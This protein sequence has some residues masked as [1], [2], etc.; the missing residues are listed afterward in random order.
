MCSSDLGR[1]RRGRRR[2]HR[3]PARRAGAPGLL[4]GQPPGPA[5]PRRRSRGRRLPDRAHRPGRPDRP[6]HRH[7][8]E[9]RRRPLPLRPRRPG[10]TRP[11]L[12]RGLQHPGRRPRPAAA[13]H[14]QPPDRHRR[15]RGA[16]SFKYSGS[17]ANALRRSRQA[18]INARSPRLAGPAASAAISFG[19]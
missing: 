1:P 6:P 11:G 13:R 17:Q 5:A 12:L 2:R 10:P 7:R 19:R 9:A 16:V 15:E 8:A 14:R 18:S 4:R 3:G